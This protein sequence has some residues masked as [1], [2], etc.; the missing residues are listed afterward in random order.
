MSHGRGP[1]TRTGSGRSSEAVR[2]LRFGSVEIVVHDGRVV[3]IETREKVRF[4]DAGRRRP[5]HPG[6]GRRHHGRAHRDQRRRRATSEDTANESRAL[7][8]GPAGR[9]G[10]L[11]ASRPGGAA[12]RPPRLAGS[13]GRGAVAVALAVPHA[14][15]ARALRGRLPER[16]HPAVRDRRLRP[17]A[18]RLRAGATAAS[19]SATTRTLVTN[20]FLLRRVRPIVQGTVAKYFDFY[21]IP[22]FGGGTTV[23]QDAYLDVRFTPKLRVPRGQDEDARSASSACSRRRAS[24]SWSARCPTTSCPTA[25][26]ACRCTA[27]WREGVFGYQA[28]GPQRRAGRRQRRHRHQ[29]RQGPRRPRVPPALEEQGH[30]AAAR[31][32]L[33]GRGH[34]RARPTAP[35]AAY[36]LGLAGAASSRYARHGHRERRPQA[37]VA[38]GAASSWAPSASSPNTCRSSTR[39]RRSRR[40]S[41]PSPRT[42][43]NSAWSVTGSVLAHRR[44]RDATASVKPKNFFVPSAGK[45]GALQLVGAR[46]PP[47]RRRGRPSPAGSPTP[48]GPCAQATAWGVGLNWIWNSNLKYVLDYEQTRFKG[49]AAGGADRPTEK[50]VQTRLQL[51][52]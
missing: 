20:Q 33:R 8:R 23:L 41:P 3:Q 22:D 52:F 46:Q 7:D 5:G 47:R 34:A 25:T 21:I 35:C 49:G 14:G 28:R 31:P 13:A 26:S 18:H 30:L 4:D 24:S 42:L 12:P 10:R 44:G 27:S 51:S 6:A 16:L 39:C 17:E 40:A 45:W 36:S 43:K 50:S 9:A 11:A 1:G 38:A 2:G 37:L 48:R 19:R 29:R 32:G 15:A